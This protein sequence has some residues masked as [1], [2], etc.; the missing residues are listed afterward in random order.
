MRI[1]LSWSGPLSHK[2][3]LE[4]Y[5]W[6]PQVI[7]VIE[8]FISS[9]GIEKGTRWGNEIA[10]NL[11]SLDVGILCLTRENI[12]APWL[13]FEAGALSKSLNESRVIP[14]LFA[15]ER[16]DVTWPLAQFQSTI[17]EKNDIQKML[18]TIARIAKEPRLNEAVILRS[19]EQWWPTLEGKLSNLSTQA[20]LAVG[21]ESKL[22]PRRTDDILEEL[23][24]LARS[25]ERSLNEIGSSLLG[26]TRRTSRPTIDV[27]DLLT[28]PSFRHLRSEIV[29]IQRTLSKPATNRSNAQPTMLIDML[30]DTVQRFHQ[31]EREISNI[32]TT[33]ASIHPQSA[34]RPIAPPRRVPTPAQPDEQ[35]NMPPIA[36]APQRPQTTAQQP[37][38]PQDDDFD[39]DLDDVPFD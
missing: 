29:R 18:L 34:S 27:V 17:Y 24:E 36:R 21:D 11:E 33:D 20:S 38:Q 12:H 25:Q 30:R 32:A 22:N 8:P 5:D 19:F 31:F 15:M 10:Q 28:L 37:S 6:L 7:Q 13:N 2:V 4:L 16:S 35:E 23:L 9:E 39:S 14:F 26:D 1:F 3:A